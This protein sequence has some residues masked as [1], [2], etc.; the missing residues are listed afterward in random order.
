MNKKIST[1]CLT[2]TLTFPPQF[3]Q[4]WPYT[5]YPASVPRLPHPSVLCIDYMYIRLMYN[6]QPTGLMH[7]W[8]EKQ[9]TGQ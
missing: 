5:V 2:Y 4:S 3:K 6:E 9:N 8:N 1:I 7:R